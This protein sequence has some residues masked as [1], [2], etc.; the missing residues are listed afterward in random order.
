METRKITKMTARA[1]NINKR[2]IGR[3]VVRGRLGD[4]SVH[5]STNYRYRRIEYGLKGLMKTEQK[6]KKRAERL[7]IKRYEKS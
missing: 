4:F 7:T 3:I 1:C 2:V 5:D 6:L